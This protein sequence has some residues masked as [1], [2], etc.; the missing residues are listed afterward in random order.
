MGHN[1]HMFE[2]DEALAILVEAKAVEICP[3]HN[4][5]W[6]RVGDVDAERRAY[7]IATN[8]QKSGKIIG[9]REDIM[10]S[11]KDVLDQAADGECPECDGS[12]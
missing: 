2:D 12:A 11:L 4:D 7:A 9:E 5:V 10:E 3:R 8:W 1:D 6:I